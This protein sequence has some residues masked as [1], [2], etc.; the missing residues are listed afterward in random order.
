MKIYHPFYKQ[1]GGIVEPYAPSIIKGGGFLVPPE[2]WLIDELSK[3]W[4]VN[5]V[6]R[7]RPVR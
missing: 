7:W 2:P 1:N 6:D 3:K 4:V 5:I